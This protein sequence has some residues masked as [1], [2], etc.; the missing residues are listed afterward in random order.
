MKGLQLLI[1]GP[2]RPETITP[3]VPAPGRSK[4]GEQ[5]IGTIMVDG[6]ELSDGGGATGRWTP[7]STRN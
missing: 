7:D 3:E 5:L 4:D 2:H 6:I 1:G